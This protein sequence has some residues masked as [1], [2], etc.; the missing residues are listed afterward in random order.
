MTTHDS[1]A[2]ADWRRRIGALYARVRAAGSD[3]SAAFTAFWT[4]RDDMVRTHRAS[5]LSPERRAAFAGFDHHP[6]DLAL[7][8]TLPLEP[9]DPE[10]DGVEADTALEVRLAADG[11]VHLQ[12]VG[13]V[14]FVLNDEACALTVFWLG[15]YGGGLFLPFGDASNGRDSY[16]GGRYLLDGVKGADLGSDGE[17]LVLD[18]NYAYAPSCALDPRW[19]CPLAP[20]ENRLRVSVDAGER[21]SGPEATISNVSMA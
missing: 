10:R 16:G 15:G 8:F 6:Y 5:P 4:E 17:R 3:D 9:I 21:R 14:R 20:P 18:F 7:R 19:D 13:R 12:R 11:V 2:L 1:L